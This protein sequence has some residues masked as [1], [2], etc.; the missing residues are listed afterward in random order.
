MEGLEAS[1]EDGSHHNNPDNIYV[2]LNNQPSELLQTVKDLKAELWTVKEGNE[3]ILREHE[4][5]TQILLDKLH[6]EGMGKRKKHEY[7]SGTISYKHKGKKL[8]FSNNESNSSSRIKVRSHREKNKYNS[9]SV[10]TSN[11]PKNLKF[12]K[13]I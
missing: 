3:R 7:E 11:F 2:E 12:L 6:N 1:A 9:E 4:E 10:N 13:H 8:K 5:L